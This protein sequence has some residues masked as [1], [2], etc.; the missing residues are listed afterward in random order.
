LT[1]A[2]HPADLLENQIVEFPGRDLGKGGVP[3]TDQERETEEDLCEIL[4][5]NAGTHIGFESFRDN[6]LMLSS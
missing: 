6:Y 3:C 2:R 5:Q 1:A 4:F